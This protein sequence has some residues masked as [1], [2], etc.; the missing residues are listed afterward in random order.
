MLALGP[1]I[2]IGCGLSVVGETPLDRGDGGLVGSDGSIVGVDGALPEGSAPPADGAVADAPSECAAWKPR[3]FVPCSLPGPG[4]AVTTVATGTLTYDTDIPG[5]SGAGAPPN[6]PSAIVDQGGTPAVVISVDAFTVPAGGTLRVVGAKPLIIAAWS[7]ITIDGTLDVGSH[8]T[9][10]RAGAGSN[11]EICKACAA[12]AGKDEAD[13]G[14]GSGGGGGGAFAGAGGGGGPGDS[15]KQ[16]AGGAGGKKV[17]APAIVRGGCSGAMSGKAGPDSSVTSPSSST[18]TAPGGAA[19]GAIEL[20]ARSTVTVSA[21]GRVVAG[22]AGGGGAPLHSAVGGGGGGAGG[23]IGFDAPKLVFVSG[24]V[25]A[26]NGGGGGAS[27]AFAST[28]APGNDG[29]ASATPAAG[30]AAGSC[31]V[32]GAAGGAGT[33]IDGANAG[34][35]DVACGGAGGGG[36]AGYV[37]VFASGFTPPAG[38]VFSPAP[39]IP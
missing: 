17:D 9:E 14:G 16:N 6:P 8:R 22:G 13:N 30:G 11:P 23:Y 12:V 21:T 28:G 1:V 19:G 27:N 31:A 38:V 26:A 20:A 5:F 7:S 29:A 35:D 18:T 25:I 33:S 24:A 15:G 32:Q 10:A 4:G 36:G 2:G 3:H 37:M 34:Q 39:T